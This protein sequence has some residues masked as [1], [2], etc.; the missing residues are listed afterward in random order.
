[1]ITSFLKSISSALLVALLFGCAAPKPAITPTPL[2]T[3]QPALHS[4]LART[5]AAPEQAGIYVIKLIEVSKRPN[6]DPPPDWQN[7][8]IPSGEVFYGENDSSAGQYDYPG[9]QM[10][11]EPDGT[12]VG[13]ELNWKRVLLWVPAQTFIRQR[14]TPPKN[15]WVDA[16]TVNGPV[17][18]LNLGD[19][20][21][22]EI[23]AGKAFIERLVAK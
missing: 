3:A 13:V 15:V 2:A 19:V 6:L 14:L 23:K 21:D 10:R 1:M 11:Y 7:K 5:V 16:G 17:D 20:W 22:G 8:L 18:Y 9:W 4:A 12:P